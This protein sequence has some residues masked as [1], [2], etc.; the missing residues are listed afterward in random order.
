MVHALDMVV[1][2]ITD[3]LS[4]ATEDNSNTNTRMGT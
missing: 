3:E 4:G 1:D 2:P